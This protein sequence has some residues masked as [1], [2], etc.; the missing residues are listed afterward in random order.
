MS[1][2]FISKKKRK[3]INFIKY[4]L[5]IILV[6]IMYEVFSSLILN[7]KLANSN[8]EFLKL[9]LKDSNHHLLYE[10]SNNN[11]AN[12]FINTITNI[13][14]NRPVSILENTFNYKQNKENKKMYVYKTAS[15]NY[16]IE[17]ESKY[18]NDTV[19]TNSKSPLVY[20][21]NTHQLE[22]YNK[23]NLEKHNITPNV[24]MGSY[25]LREKLN[26]KNIPTVVETSN[27]TDFLNTNGWSYSYSYK[28]SRYFL[29]DAIN[30]YKDLKLII[31]LHRDSIS[32]KASTVTINNKNYAKILFVI[33]LEHKNYNK[34][35]ETVSKINNI[36]NK[37]YPNISRGIIKKEGKNVNGIYNQDLSEKIILIECGGKDNTID[38]VLNTL[39][40]LADVIYSYIGGSNG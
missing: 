25:I 33:G 40:I 22:G 21:Y 5:I 32:K 19:N 34:N 30:K 31:D 10:K 12:K 24:L 38:E 18:V 17:K 6:F 20:I 27:I 23:T 39:E 29:K 1:K 37:K 13:E 15:D 28:A 4:I 8:E 3:K 11:I 26:K 14:I 2:K 35:L 7:I 9:L 36:L 16:E